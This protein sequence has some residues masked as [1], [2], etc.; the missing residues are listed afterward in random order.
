MSQHFYLYSFTRYQ[1]ETRRKY[2]SESVL[3]FYT[4]FFPI[5]S[6]SAHTTLPQ[7]NKFFR[8]VTVTLF[9]LLL[10]PF[11][12]SRLILSITCEINSFEMYL[13]AA[14]NQMTDSANTWI[15][16]S[17]WNNIKSN[18]LYHHYVAALAWGLALSC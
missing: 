10:K 14:N 3:Y 6:L 18:A 7:L 12:C 9:R 13:G 2:S 16:G 11:S 8:P 1:N 5:A 15:I 17:K 4:T